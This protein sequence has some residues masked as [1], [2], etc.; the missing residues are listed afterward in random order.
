MSFPCSGVTPTPNDEQPVL[1]MEEPRLVLVPSSD[2]PPG[3]DECEPVQLRAERA[4]R[5]PDATAVEAGDESLRNDDAPDA[6]HVRPRE[7]HALRGKR[8]SADPHRHHPPVGPDGVVHDYGV[9]VRQRSEAL[10]ARRGGLDPDRVRLD[11]PRRR[12]PPTGPVDRRL[13]LRTWNQCTQ[14]GRV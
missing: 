4:A 10:V 13:E 11:A 8:P 12:R 3:R 5:S 2:R 9:S 6:R 7:L 14:F 1:L